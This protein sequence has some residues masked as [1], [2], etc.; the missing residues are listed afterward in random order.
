[1][2]PP[3]AYTPSPQII[4]PTS[5]RTNSAARAAGLP[6]DNDRF[7][8]LCD[9]DTVFVIDDSYSMGGWASSRNSHSSWDEVATLLR[10][11]APICTAR[12]AD[13]IDI[14]FLNHE[15][16]GL[17]PAGKAPG[18]YYN[19]CNAEAVKRIFKGTEPDGFTPTGTRLESILGAYMD[20]LEA[21]A[22]PKDIKPINVIVITDGRPTDDP[23]GVLVGIAMR[24]SQIRAPASQ[25]GVQFFQVGED[26]EAREALRELDDGLMKH[27][28]RDIV[29]AVTWDGNGRRGNTL[30]AEGVLKVVLG[31][32][33]RRL[34]WKPM[35]G[36]R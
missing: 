3:P 13:G 31:A 7:A 34:D 36:G 11:V 5:R 26:K 9:F 32:V 1:M 15:T 12:D 4:P 17:P 20:R 29:D 6:A 23:A 30:T 35:D 27:A 14:Y 25:L 28:G 16:T 19:V 18:G 2:D 33:S 8:F 21:A 10:S 24:L 22:N